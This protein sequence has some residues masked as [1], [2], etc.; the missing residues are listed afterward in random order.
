MSRNI[1]EICVDS[2]A[3]ALAARAGRI[4]PP[5]AP[6]VARMPL[7]FQARAP[8]PSPLF[9]LRYHKY[10]RYSTVSNVPRNRGTPRSRS[11]TA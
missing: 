6:L 8:W 2:T 11:T 1:L 10:S 4:L 9:S 5:A 3:S 7:L